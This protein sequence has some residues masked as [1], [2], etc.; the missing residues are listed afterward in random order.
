MHAEVGKK[1]VTQASSG[2]GRCS[3]LAYLSGMSLGFA[4]HPWSL[5]RSRRVFHNLS[6][7]L[8]SVRGQ[9]S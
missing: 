2:V 9:G 4:T 8:E 1:R 5:A 6:V 3:F 7:N